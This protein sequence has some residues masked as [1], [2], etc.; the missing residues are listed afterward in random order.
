MYE[1]LKV[2]IIIKKVIGYE[3]TLMHKA[4]RPSNFL[5]QHFHT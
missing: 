5:F 1:N 2:S 4:D 3:D